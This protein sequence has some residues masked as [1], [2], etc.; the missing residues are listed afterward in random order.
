MKV[1]NCLSG[2]V[3]VA[4]VFLFYAKAH[5]LLGYFDTRIDSSVEMAGGGTIVEGTWTDC[6]TVP[7]TMFR[8]CTLKG[9][10]FKGGIDSTGK[11]YS[12]S[13]TP[14][15]MKFKFTNMKALANLTPTVGSSGFFFIRKPSAKYQATSF[16][17][18]IPTQEVGGKKMAVSLPRDPS[19]LFK[20][21]SRIQPAN[22]K[23]LGTGEQE[24]LTKALQDFTDYTGGKNLGISATPV[25]QVTGVPANSVETI[26]KAFVTQ[27][28]GNQK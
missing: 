8:E 12:A 14:V 25:G 9:K 19:L 10:V 24:N 28:Y 13:D 5:A 4:L 1:K 20:D 3:M 2:L 18:S 15:E 26:I 17:N 7:N 6:K 23:G 16:I 27:I 22:M 21:L 11:S